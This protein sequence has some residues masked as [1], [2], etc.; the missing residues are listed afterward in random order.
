M[1]INEAKVHKLLL[2]NP[3][4]MLRGLSV[5]HSEFSLLPAYSVLTRD[6]R[7][8]VGFGSSNS[9][10]DEGRIIGR[11]DVILKYQRALYATEIKYAKPTNTSSDFWESLKILGYTEY[12]KWQ[13]D[14][15]NIHPAIMIPLHSIKLEQQIVA[16]KLGL[17]IFAIYEELGKIKIKKLDDRPIWK[18]K[19]SPLK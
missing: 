9:S 15:T 12:F 18:Q 6:V 16:G 13:T 14:I 17:T 5:S 10:T 11:I 8:T 2:E 4:K 7:E 19:E 1:K 3:E